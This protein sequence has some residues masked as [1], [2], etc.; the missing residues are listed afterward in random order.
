M[1]LDHQILLK[2]P[3]LT[4]LAGSTP[5]V[6][7]IFQKPTWDLNTSTKSSLTFEIHF[8]A[9]AKHTTFVTDLFTTDPLRIGLFWRGTNSSY[10]DTCFPQIVL[11]QYKAMPYLGFQNL[12]CHC[13]NLGCHFDTS[14]RLKHCQ[15]GLS[16]LTNNILVVSSPLK[17]IFN[18]VILFYVLISD[19]TSSYYRD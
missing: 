12:G 1:R 16:R 11:L 10:P 9:H 14:K 19:S 2:S 18:R 3:S 17:P 4:L 7:G 8:N 5:G 6:N 15:K 13:R